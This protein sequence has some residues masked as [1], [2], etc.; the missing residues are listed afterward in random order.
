MAKPLII[1]ESPTK[2]KTVAKYLGNDYKVAAT[3][4]HIK[5]LPKN[6]LGVDFEHGFEPQYAEIDNK[7]KVI[8]DLKKAAGSA[9]DIYLASD[10][11]REGEAIAWH[12]AEVLQKKG[13]KFH[14]VLFHEL[15]K[16][17]I[18][19]AMQQPQDLDGHKYEAQ[20]ARRVLDRIVGYE[21]SPLLWK[22]V[23]RGLSAGRVQSVAVRIIVERERAIW[24]F[25]KEEFWSITADLKAEKAK[26]NAKLV[27]KNDKKLTIANETEAGAIVKELEQAEFVVAKTVRKTVK[28]NPLPPFTTSKLQQD[29][30][31]RLHFSSKKTMQIAQQ[32]YEGIELGA[33]GAQGLITYMRT[34]STRISTEAAHEARDMITRQFGPEYAL[35]KPRFFKNSKKAQDAHEAIRPTSVFNT[36]DKI[37]PF[38]SKDQYALYRLVWERFVASQ[39]AQALLNQMTITI[40]AGPYSFTS[41]GSTIK[42]DGYLKLYQP[43]ETPED[44]EDENNANVILPEINDGQKLNLKKLNPKQHFTQPPPRFSEASLVKELEENGIGRPSTYAAILST[45]KDKGYVTLEKRYFRPTEL[46]IIVNDMLVTHFPQIFN[47]TFTAQM[48]ENLDAIENSELNLNKLMQSFYPEFEAT[49]K[50]ATDDAVSIKGVGLPTGLKCPKCNNGELTIRIGKF[51][52]YLSCDKYPECDFSSDYSRNEEGKVE[53]TLREKTAAEATGRFCP[54]CESPLVIKNGRFGEFLACSAYP[55]CKYTETM[56]TENAEDNNAPGLIPCP[57]PKCKGQIVEK[58]S[59]SGKVFYGCNKYPDCNFALW[60]K[61]NPKACP[62][63][64]NPYLLEKSTKKEGA[65]LSCPN[66]ECGYKEALIPPQKSSAK[67]KADG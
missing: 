60:D 16:N 2:V 3:V 11:D 67:V 10:P 63:C 52:H 58:K 39:M 41:G 12:A 13:R 30:I 61:P 45:I 37:K 31:N 36:P 4:G 51:G 23:Q 5:D 24:A 32:L 53:Y 22:K 14:R 7:K 43:A 15:T 8:S 35:E 55:K 26:L 9:T 18:L 65:F 28:K 21:A 57:N 6:N 25:K 59:R 40:N 50:K 47:V 33:E 46:G 64:Q 17:A 19:A 38:L 34:D 29:A 20:K 66:K 56:R 1:V 48:E 54:K 44:G 62:Q 49:V 27:R 42:F